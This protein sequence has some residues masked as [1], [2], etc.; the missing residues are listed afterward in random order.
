MQLF[1][2]VT[3]FVILYLK[4]L[5]PW[6]LRWGATD[7]EVKCAMFGDNLVQNHNC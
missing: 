1:T 4:I 5:R 7:D 6:Q 2:F 3:I